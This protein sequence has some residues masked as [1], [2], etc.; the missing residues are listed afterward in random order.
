MGMTR[1]ENREWRVSTHSR[2]FLA[3]SSI[4][5]I[6]PPTAASSASF[7]AVPDHPTSIV[8]P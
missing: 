7:L 6:A 5:S 4:V 2:P 3:M 1:R 8:S